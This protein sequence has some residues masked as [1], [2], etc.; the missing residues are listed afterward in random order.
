MVFIFWFHYLSIQEL[1]T[2]AYVTT[3]ERHKQRERGR[4]RQSAGDKHK[5]HI[6]SSLGYKAWLG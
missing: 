2:A 3:Q 4:E 5:H 1:V 6:H